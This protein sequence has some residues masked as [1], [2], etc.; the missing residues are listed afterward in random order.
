MRIIWFIWKWGSFAIMFY[1]LKQNHV[2]LS[3]LYPVNDCLQLHK[4]THMGL[5]FL[6]LMYPVY[7]ECK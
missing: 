6:S 1:Y 5:L 3:I 2:T 7:Q 4:H